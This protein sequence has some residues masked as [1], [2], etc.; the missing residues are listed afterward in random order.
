MKKPQVDME[1]ADA[2]HQAKI[3]A[4][5]N[6]TAPVFVEK[7]KAPDSSS[8]APEA[9]DARWRAKIEARK[10]ATQ[11]PAAPAT[12]EAS[13]PASVAGSPAPQVTEASEP[14]IGK[15]SKAEKSSGSQRR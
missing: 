12:K 2:R 13:A 4:R 9:V 3:Q 7:P 5:A 6:G 8:L 14:T 11:A 10:A 15:E 1:A